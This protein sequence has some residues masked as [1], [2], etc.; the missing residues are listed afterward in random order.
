MVGRWR[1]A[2]KLRK[3]AECDT[4]DANALTNE[5]EQA[6]IKAGVFPDR[7]IDE[8]GTTLEAEL[9]SEKRAIEFSRWL[10]AKRHPNLPMVRARVELVDGQVVEH[11][12]PVNYSPQELHADLDR[13]GVPRINKAYIRERFCW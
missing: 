13:M 8:K 4:A 9:L 5:I 10:L 11:F 2:Q 3:Q 12:E 6:A 7:S 1:V